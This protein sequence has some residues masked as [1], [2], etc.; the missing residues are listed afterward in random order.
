MKVL[1]VEDQ[2]EFFE[3]T[4]AQLTKIVGVE[5][6]H[7]STHTEALSLLEDHHIDY[8]ILDLAIPYQ[9]LTDNPDKA[10]GVSV[11]HKIRTQYPGTPILIFSAQS[12]EEEAEK[13]EE[14]DTHINFWDGKYKNIVK[15]RNKRKLPEV[16]QLIKEAN[17]SLIFLNQIEVIHNDK[18]VLDNIQTRVIQL[19]CIHKNAIA[20]KVESL[21]EGL[22]TSKVLRVTLLNDLGKE[23][24]LALAK[25]DDKESIEAETDNFN[26]Y[27]QRLPVA[28]FP[29]FLDQYFAGCGQV[30]GVFFQYAEN[31]SSDYFSLLLS[32][33]QQAQKLIF[34]IKSLFNNWNIDKAPK[35]LQISEIRNFLC[36]D[37]KFNQ[38]KHYLQDLNIDEFEQKSLR[39]T[40]T[41]QHGDLHGKNILVSE[42][43]QPLIIDYGDIKIAPSTIDAV[44]LELSPF[45]HPS[46]RDKVNLIDG[47]A[48]NWF[49]DVNYIKYCE[50]P[51][52]FKTLREWARENAILRKEY[53]AVVYAYAVRQLTYEDTN[54]EFAIK[55]I[56]SAIENVN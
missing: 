52:A 47:L 14:D 8:A 53:A 18:L 35:L 54:K 46:S 15:I 17:Q 2:P 22:S 10:H 44:T 32:S 31:F 40:M 20:A 12:T 30:K 39:V 55:L 11:A 5:V 42:N 41:I 1:H 16:I 45:F 26:S 21:D 43:N 38:I 49:D 9:S 3:I 29:S 37:K 56:H 13:F 28:C 50:F 24:F 34:E 51:L 7:A 4:K 36:S 19:F 27:I 48:E 6:F 25:I 33:D 23:F